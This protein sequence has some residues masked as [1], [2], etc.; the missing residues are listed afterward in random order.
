MFELTYFN[1]AVLAQWCNA[2]LWGLALFVTWRGLQAQKPLPAPLAQTGPDAPLVSILVP[3]RNEANRVLA[4]S[5]A[6]MLAQD[7][8]NF[9]IIA[10]NDRSTDA[11]GAILHNI[12][13]QD[14]RL[15]VIE[16]T[17][18]PA[19]W[20][21]KPHAMAQAAAAARGVWLLATDA[22]MMYA[23]HAV[24][25]VTEYARIGKYDAVT[26]LPH[27]V[28]GSFWE[29]IFLPAFGWFMLLGMPVSRVNDPQRPES[30]GVGGFFLWRREALAA[31]GGYAAVRAEVAEDLRLGALLKHKGARLRLEYGADLV[32]TRMQT[33]LRDLWEG[34]SKNLFAGMQF[35]LGAALA[36][37]LGITLGAILPFLVAIFC[38]AWGLTGAARAW[39]LLAPSGAV[40]L[41][42][43]ALFA[44]INKSWGVPLRYALTVPLGFALFVA[45]LFN[46]AY[47]IRAGRGVMWKGRS[48]YGAD[49]VRPPTR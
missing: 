43:V 37:G 22:D 35:R 49:G 27:V 4:D 48:I 21:G 46:S 31:V 12:A 29:R 19:G 1:G 3:A 15:R 24:R 30:S 5:L 33:N 28:C 18:T 20:L 9:E 45:V 42:Q 40:W 23:P 38:L 7:Y 17:E 44:L 47:R 34:F 13:A 26:L 6:T 32:S 8:G 36:G 41:A 16:G 10:V 39:R 2:V 25:T 14:A 11:T